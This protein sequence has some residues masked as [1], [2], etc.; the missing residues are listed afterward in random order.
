ML[1]LLDAV[2]VL[3]DQGRALRLVVSGIGPDTDTVAER[4][5]ELSGRG[6]GI[7]AVGR[8]ERIG[9]NVTGFSDGDRVW[10]IRAG[11]AGIRK[12]TGLAAEFAVVDQRRVALAP[13]SL[14]DVQAAAL[15]V[16]GYTALRA[17]RDTVRLR[18][19][20]RAVIRGA[21][22]GVGSAAVSIAAALGGRVVGVASGRNEDAVRAG[23][24]QEFFDYAALSPSD[25]GMADVIFD[26]VGTDLLAWRRILEHDGRMAAVGVGS[27]RALTAVAVSSLH[28]SRRIRMFAGEPPAG[29]LAA[30]TA[31][32]DAHGIRPLV[33]EAFALDEIR[34]AHEAFAAR[35][36]AGKLVITV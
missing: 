15:V 22:G 32:V 5:T 21:S 35:G 7:D 30:L 6:V 9:A 10:A 11:A 2:R 18:P 13:T 25:V 31:F 27:P 28:G 3:L 24:A 1:D 29:Q 17:L 26:T 16:G 36:L 33:H 8:I 4:V 19:G 20:E 23:G 12:P 34:R 14:D